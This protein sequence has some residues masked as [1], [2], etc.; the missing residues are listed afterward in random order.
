M[1]R[2]EALEYFREELKDGKCSETCP[3]CNANEWAI[4][5]LEALE[6]PKS[7]VDSIYER[8]TQKAIDELPLPT[9][10]PAGECIAINPPIFKTEEETIPIKI[11]RLKRQR[12]G[13]RSV[14]RHLEEALYW[15]RKSGLPEEGIQALAELLDKFG[16]QEFNAMEELDK[17][18]KKE[19]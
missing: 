2:S 14:N 7:D 9:L 16:T 8:A 19:N 11:S 4:K 5:A 12:L 10:I 13:F 17:L 3:I 1:T 6:E 18:E 15:A